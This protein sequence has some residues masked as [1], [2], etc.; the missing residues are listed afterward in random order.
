MPRNHSLSL[1]VAGLLLAGSA[2]QAGTVTVVTS[3][4][5]DLTTVTV[6][7]WAA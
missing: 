5:K 3:F 4:A 2:A 7:A 6:P 1:V